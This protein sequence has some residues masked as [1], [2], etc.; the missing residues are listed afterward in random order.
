MDFGPDC[1]LTPM[2]LTERFEGLI[3]LAPPRKE[4]KGSFRDLSPRTE[5]VAPFR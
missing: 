2:L 3:A 4:G 5:L 1:S